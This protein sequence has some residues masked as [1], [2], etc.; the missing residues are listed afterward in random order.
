[1]MLKIVIMMHGGVGDWAVTMTTIMTGV[2]IGQ[3]I[4][5]ASALPKK[6]RLSSL[7]LQPPQHPPVPARRVSPEF[8]RLRM[9]RP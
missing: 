9:L 2:A 3:A 8:L 4:G 6:L 7:S 5:Q 1:M